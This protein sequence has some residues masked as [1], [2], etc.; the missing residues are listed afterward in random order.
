MNTS[1][2]EMNDANTAWSSPEA[3][4]SASASL[5]LLGGL[6]LL[7][8]LSDGLLNMLDGLL[9]VSLDEDSLKN[10]DSFLVTHSS[11]HVSHGSLGSGGGFE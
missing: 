3:S 4:S 7:D 9:G 5:D 2:T 10:S 8:D 6:C 11:N 1:D